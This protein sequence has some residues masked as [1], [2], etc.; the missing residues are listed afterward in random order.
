MH[1]RKLTLGLIVLNGM[2]W[3]SA[4]LAASE[5][6]ITAVESP[7]WIMDENTKMPVAAGERITAHSRL[8]TGNT[9]K[10]ELKPGPGTN[11]QLG[12]DS[13][14]EFIANAD[15]ET[16]SSA[17]QSTVKIHRGRICVQFQAQPQASTQFRLL[18]GGSVSAVIQGQGQLCA[19][20]SRD[21]SRI[22][23]V[24]GSL[25]IA[26]SIKPTMVVMSKPG[27][28]YRFDDTG[29]FEL[30]MIEA[31]MAIE[32][33][34]NAEPISGSNA[35]DKTSGS[36]TDRAARAA[37]GSTSDE[38]DGKNSPATN[39]M[40]SEFIYTIYL[41][42]TRSKKIATEV[43]QKLRT[44]GQQTLILATDS[45][46]NTQ[47]RIAIPGFKTRQAAQD[48]SA[49]IVGKYGIEDTWIGKRKIGE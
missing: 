14:I 21:G 7:A 12:N 43:N 29:N 6:S 26:N 48:Y 33:S 47:Y 11:L 3:F 42:S 9:G 27:S 4:A 36:E 10:L 32:V 40:E 17:P 13:E 19:V 38:A 15:S 1:T 31:E 5:I 46:E 39:D 23:L 28:E 45:G 34:N 37:T 16:A 30:G 22:V 2:C 18:L 41:F 20:L 24:Q 8:I 35:R 49:S 44:A 25:Q